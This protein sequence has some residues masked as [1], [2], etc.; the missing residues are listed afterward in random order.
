[1]RLRDTIE[2]SQFVIEEWSLQAIMIADSSGNFSLINSLDSV[3]VIVS[4][5]SRAEEFRLVVEALRVLALLVMM[6]EVSLSFSIRWLLW[7]CTSSRSLQYCWAARVFFHLLNSLRTSVLFSSFAMYWVMFLDLLVAVEWVCDWKFRE[8][9][10]SRIEVFSFHLHT[11]LKIL[12]SRP[13]CTYYVYLPG[14]INFSLR[15]WSGGKF[16][17]EIMV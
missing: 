7:F 16:S 17:S 3:T 1:M 5:L 4:T 13:G 11:E 10:I 6:V 15:K 8:R 14:F 2:D 12:K 9:Q